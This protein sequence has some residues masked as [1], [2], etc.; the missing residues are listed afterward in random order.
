M[1]QQSYSWVY[2]WKKKK[3][4]VIWKDTHTLIFIATVFTI[5]KIWKQYK[6]PSTDECIKMWYVCVHTHTHTHTQWNTTQSHQRMKLCY[7]QQ[8]EW[9]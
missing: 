5:A 9:T 8:C 4:T 7:L 6:C 1:T 3:T 2:I